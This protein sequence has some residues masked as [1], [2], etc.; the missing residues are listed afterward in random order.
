MSVDVICAGLIVADHVCAPLAKW[1][2]QGGL[3]M[4][5]RLDLSIGGCAA[6]VAVDL[7]RLGLRAA[8]AGC[9]GDDVLGR[10]VTDSLRE[11]GVDG[12]MI[13]ISQTAQTSATLVVNIV[14]ED[15]RFL[16][17]VGANVEFQGT[18]IPR[19][20]V[21]QA[22]AVYV[23]GFGLNPALSGPNV[24]ALFEAAQQ[25]GTVTLLDVVVGDPSVQ[26]EMLEPVLPFTDL[27]LPNE[28]EARLITG[29]DDPQ[30]QAALFHRMGANTVVITRGGNGSVH[31]NE[32]GW[33]IAEAYDVPVADATGGGDAFLSGYLTAY[34]Q[35]LPAEECLK[36]G[37][38]LGASCVRAMGATAGVFT[39]SELEHFLSRHDLVIQRL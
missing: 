25:A 23:G 20:K 18:E 19:E 5:D 30:R 1:P 27:F 11:Q 8:V 6:N 29:E 28:D 37:S 34:L 3:E 12:S 17:A 13:T 16:H 31:L 4:T 33:L 36:W 7:T 22:Q 39:R 38:A 24:A 32:Q 21:A 9:V 35:Q 26:M 14:G 10:F 2:P 15:R